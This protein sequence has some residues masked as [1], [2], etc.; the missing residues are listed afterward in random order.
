MAKGQ[1]FSSYQKGV[2]KRY[3]QNK[4][5]LASQ[6]LGELVSELYLADS[7]KKLDR[8]WKSVETAL[9]NAGANKARIEKV[10]GERDLSALAK[11]V[12]DIF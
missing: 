2:I 10:T 5:T 7:P 12:S 3:Y 6:K 11:L 9:V 8:L 1:H 4:D